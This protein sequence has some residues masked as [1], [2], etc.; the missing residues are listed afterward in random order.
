[1]THRWIITVKFGVSGKL[2]LSLYT[3]IKQHIYKI[4]IIPNIILFV[5]CPSRNL[6][7]IMLMTW[8]NASRKILNEI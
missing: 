3:P 1:M 6:G 2:S 8:V 5:N 7:K 4:G